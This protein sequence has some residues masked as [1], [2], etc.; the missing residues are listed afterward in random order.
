MRDV[1]GLPRASV[2][3]EEEKISRPEVHFPLRNINGVPDRGLLVGVP[4]KEDAVEI[5]YGLR[6]SRAVHPFGRGPPPEV[7]D[8]KEPFRC[9]DDPFRRILR[10]CQPGPERFRLVLRDEPRTAV[11]VFHVVEIPGAPFQG[12]KRT[13]N[14]VAHV[15]RGDLLRGAD[16]GKLRGHY[17]FRE[18]RPRIVPVLRHTLEPVIGPSQV[19]V[20][21]LHEI[22]SP[23]LLQ[24]LHGRAQESLG[25]HFRTV[26]GPGAEVR[27]AH[28]DHAECLLPHRLRGKRRDA[29]DDRVVPFFPDEAEELFL[30]A[31]VLYVAGQRQRLTGSGS[32]HVED[33]RSGVRR[34][35]RSGF[36]Q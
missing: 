25:G 26:F 8:A 11:R 35:P 33:R 14:H 29:V 18:A 32:F 27:N 2:R 19:F 17:Q 10:L 3:A 5:V 24:Y 31:G 6:E 13:R 28:V 34:E 21:R 7:G 23:L 12:K 15:L 1:F 16:P 9:R 4:R 36:T 30:H 22:P 20:R